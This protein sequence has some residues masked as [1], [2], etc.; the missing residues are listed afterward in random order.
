MAFGSSKAFAQCKY[1]TTENGKETK[2]NIPC[3]FPVKY[4]KNDPNPDKSKYLEEVTLWRKENPN[5][6]NLDLGPT[7]FP[8]NHYIE[9][10]FTNY[11]S[12]SAE[13]KD[14]LNEFPNFYRVIKTKN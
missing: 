6:V 1:V 2:L 5:L 8:N 12:F 14:L 10:P 13:R 4:S 3:N 7:S 11:N 9:I